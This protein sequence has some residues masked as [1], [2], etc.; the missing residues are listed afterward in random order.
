MSR[1]GSE[2]RM[3]DTS[4]TNKD[5]RITL[6]EMQQAALVRFD[7]FDLNHDGTIS[8]QERQ[9]AHQLFKGQKKP[10]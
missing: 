1:G 5:G 9:Q 10:Q 2:S 3:F 4:D 6:A 8:P 7:R